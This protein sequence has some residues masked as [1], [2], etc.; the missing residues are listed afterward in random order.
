MVCIFCDIPREKHSPFE[1]AECQAQ[2]AA[3]AWIG[4]SQFQP[5][6]RVGLTKPQTWAGAVDNFVDN[7]RSFVYD[8]QKNIPDFVLYVIAQCQWYGIG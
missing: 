7:F 1:L 4:L 5:H 8:L 3:G 2:G 6:R